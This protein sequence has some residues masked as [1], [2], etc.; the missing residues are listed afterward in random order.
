MKNM[1]DYHDHYLRKGVSLLAD[2]YKNFIGTCLKYYG[3]DPCHYL[4]LCGK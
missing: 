2:F 4:M 3:L 1:D